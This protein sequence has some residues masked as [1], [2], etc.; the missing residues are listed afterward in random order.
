MTDIF[1]HLDTIDGEVVIPQF[2][3]QIEVASVSSGLYI[4]ARTGSLVSEVI[5]AAHRPV[6]TKPMDS[7]SVK[8][9]QALLTGTPLANGVISFWDPARALVYL[10]INLDYVYVSD[11]ESVTSG[12]DDLPHEQVTLAVARIRWTYTRKNPDGTTSKTTFGWDFT[13][14]GSF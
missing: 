10:T 13:R 9:A 7:A 3:G 12:T 5:P 4:P 6:I 8:L 1:L 11:I 14:G 2:K